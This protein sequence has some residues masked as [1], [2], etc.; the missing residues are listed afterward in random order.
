MGNKHLGNPRTRVS[1]RSVPRQLL[2][3]RWLMR[4]VRVLERRVEA[5][6]TRT[7]IER[8]LQLAQLV[9]Q[10]FRDQMAQASMSAV[11]GVGV[12]YVD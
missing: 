6:E 11:S 5:L 2:T 1:S 3:L 10:N 9:K 7:K 8:E 4:R 12:S